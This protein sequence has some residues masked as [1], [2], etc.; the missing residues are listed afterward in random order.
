MPVYTIPLTNT[1]QN[2]QV[3]LL[4]V[5]YSLTVRWNA[6]ASL[7]YLDIDDVN[8][9]PILNGIP[10]VAGVNLLKQY[11]YLGIGGALV[12]QNVANPNTPI[13]KTDLGKTG[14]L[15]FVVASG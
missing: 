6:L 15:L 12:A 5:T 4:G 11:A 9:N 10:M 14:F 1:N 7:W 13:G 3:S 2:V 8:S